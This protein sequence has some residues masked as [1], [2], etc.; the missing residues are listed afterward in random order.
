MMS[1]PQL[2]KPRV[3]LARFL[4]P[5]DRPSLKI[6]FDNVRNYLICGALL[7]LAGWLSTR[8]P[9][10]APA[11]YKPT[12]VDWSSEILA[13]KALFGILTIGNLA[14][15][16]LICRSIL[17]EVFG[18]RTAVNDRILPWFVHVLAYV[19]ALLLTLLMLAIGI[20]LLMVVAN[21]MW[22]AA[23]NGKP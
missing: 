22:Y 9:G 10:T 6:V 2:N 18:P 21:L 17:I 14:Q 13:C 7:S 19:I 5:E 3:R 11:F 16:V 15:S 20:T 23:S 1:N 12:K 4:L 8:A